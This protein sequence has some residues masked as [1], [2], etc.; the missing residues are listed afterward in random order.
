MDAFWVQE[1][2]LLDA[3]SNKGTSSNVD[4]DSEDCK[5]RRPDRDILPAN[6]LVVGQEVTEADAKAMKEMI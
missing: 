3:T 6:V 1:R 2:N 5:V 4:S